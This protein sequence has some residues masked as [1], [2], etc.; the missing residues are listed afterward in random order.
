MNTP[1]RAFP[2]SPR[3]VLGLFLVAGGVLLAL[4]RFGYLDTGPI[5]RFW[6]V[7]LVVLGLLKLASPAGRGGGVVLLLI[8]G[9]FLIDNLTAL[10]LD[11]SDLVPFAVALV[12]LALVLGS[13]GRRRPGPWRRGGGVT[14]L[15]APLA[16]SASTVEGFAILGAVSR[17]NNSPQFRGGTATAVAGG[18]ELD[19]RHAAIGDGPAVIDV[20]AW[21][22]GVEILVPESWTVDVRGTALLGA[23]EDLTRPPLGGPSQVLVIR[24]LVIMGAVEVKN[25]PRGERR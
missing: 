19:L 18:V 3:L 5:W 7:V 24:G 8:G 21:W 13:F 23:I 22:G 1:E 16:G 10:D 14:S 25:D 20:F 15:G 12:G 4:D 2:I 6:P 11:V 9:W 17:T